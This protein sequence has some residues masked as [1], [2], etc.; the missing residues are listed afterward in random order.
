MSWFVPALLKHTF[1]ASFEIFVAPRS[2]R[3]LC[4]ARRVTSFTFRIDSSRKRNSSYARMF[5]VERPEK[6]VLV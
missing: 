1:A 4:S 3:I 6:A 2:E 5:V